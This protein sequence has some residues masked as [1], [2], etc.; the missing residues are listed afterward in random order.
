MALESWIGVERLTHSKE[1]RDSEGVYWINKVT[2]YGIYAHLNP[3]LD[4][5]RS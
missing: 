1:G 5:V 4:Y 3:K 2:V